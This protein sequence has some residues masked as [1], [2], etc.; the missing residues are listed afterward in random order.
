MGS[1]LLGLLGS[2]AFGAVACPRLGVL[3]TLGLVLRRALLAQDVAP[4]NSQRK[5]ALE[6]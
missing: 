4:F 6:V 2:V 3:D 5:L 1:P